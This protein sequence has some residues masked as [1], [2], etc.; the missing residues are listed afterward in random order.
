MRWYRSSGISGARPSLLRIR[1]ILLPVTKRTCA[2]PWLSRR[3]EPTCDG[4]TPLRA[5]LTICCTTSSGVVF[6]HD[7]GERTYGSAEP[8]IPFPFASR[9]SIA[10]QNTST[11]N[12][13]DPSCLNTGGTVSTC[14]K[15]QGAGSKGPARRNAPA[16]QRFAKTSS[17]ERRSTWRRRVGHSVSRVHD[18]CT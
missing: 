17:M 10:A 6:S 15:S 5:I 13:C 3:S 1:R 14:S 7:G 2:M 8:L 12:A 16:S 4:V 11:Y 18:I 9:V